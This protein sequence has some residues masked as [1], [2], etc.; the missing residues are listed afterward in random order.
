MKKERRLD[1]HKRKTKHIIVPK[2]PKTGTLR[3]KKVT[4]K[5]SKRNVSSLL[6]LRY[7]LNR[8]N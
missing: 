5:Y 7:V 6:A 1:P 2:R 8:S 3:K 4:K